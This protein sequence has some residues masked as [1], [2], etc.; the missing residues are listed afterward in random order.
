MG[1]H[2]RASAAFAQTELTHFMRDF[3]SIGVVIPESRE[4]DSSGTYFTAGAK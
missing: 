3:N 4:A 2:G 1:L